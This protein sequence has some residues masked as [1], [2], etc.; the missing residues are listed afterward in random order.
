[1][2]L[3]IIIIIKHSLLKY[4]SNFITTLT[5]YAYLIIKRRVKNVGIF[6]S[7][8]CIIKQMKI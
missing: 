7:T 3:Q 6:D 5:F 8:L 1:M 4:Y 2:Y